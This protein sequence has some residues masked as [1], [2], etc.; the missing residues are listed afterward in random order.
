MKTYTKRIGKSKNNIL[1]EVTTWDGKYPVLVTTPKYPTSNQREETIDFILHELDDHD[2]YN[3]YLN[4]LTG[5][6][7]E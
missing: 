5:E 2:G 1:L 3:E 4:L 7:N 6:E